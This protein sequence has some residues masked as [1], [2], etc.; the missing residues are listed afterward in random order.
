LSSYP[1]FTFAEWSSYLISLSTLN[2]QPFL[3]LIIGRVISFLSQ[4]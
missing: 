4:H 3:A 1:V 2:G